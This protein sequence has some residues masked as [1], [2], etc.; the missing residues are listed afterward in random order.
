M[1]F[2]SLV[3]LQ[4]QETFHDTLFKGQKPC[5]VGSLDTAAPSRVLASEMK[6][7]IKAQLYLG[8]DRPG[9]L[10]QLLKMRLLLSSQG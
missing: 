2:L 10:T 3:F 1:D 5:P 9:L 4:S 7:E 8:L 6:A